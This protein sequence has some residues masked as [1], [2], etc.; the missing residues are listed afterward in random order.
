[1]DERIYILTDEYQDV[2]PSQF[3]EELWRPAFGLPEL[4]ILKFTNIDEKINEL[5]FHF[6]FF[7]DFDFHFHFH[8]LFL[9]L[10]L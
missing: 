5:V 8:F 4:E 2:T 3:I 10:F 7:F 6:L 1:M 9:V